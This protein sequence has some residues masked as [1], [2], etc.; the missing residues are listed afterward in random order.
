MRLGHIFG[1][2]KASPLLSFEHC[3]Q[4]SLIHEAD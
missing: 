1:E 3:L 4:V 2:D